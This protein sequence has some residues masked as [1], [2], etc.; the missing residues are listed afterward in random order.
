MGFE[1]YR[2]GDLLL[3]AGTQEVTRNGESVPVPRLSFR[4]LLSLARHAPNVVSTQKLEEEVWSGLVVDKGTINKRVLLLRKALGEDR[5]QGPYITVIRGSGYRMDI[6]V[7]RIA[8]GPDQPESATKDQTSLYQR[9]SGVVRTASYWLLGVV[10]VL[11]LYQGVRNTSQEPADAGPQPKRIAATQAVVVYERQ[12]VAVLPFVDLSGSTNHQFMGDGL[13][14]EIINLLAGMDGLKVAARTSSFAFRETSLTAMEIAQE[15]KVGTILEGSIRLE[16]EDIH[17][18]AQL[19]DTRTGY[20]IWS[21]TYDRTLEQVFGVQDDIAINIAEALKLTLDESQRPDSGKDTTHDIEAFSMYLKGR[22]LMNDRIQLRTEG[23]KKALGLFRQ[24]VQRDQKFARAHAGIAAVYWLLTAYD[25]SLDREPYFEQA[26]ASAQY[27]LEIDPNSTD[28]MGVLA[29]IYAAR[30]DIEKAVMMFN[31]IRE[32]GSNDSNIV[33]W[34]AML[35][36]RL[37]YFSG[38]INEL[39]ETYRRDPL[40]QHIGWSLAAAL[41]FSGRP[42]EAAKILVELDDFAY[43]DH[44]LG[45]TSIYTG[46]YQQARGYLRDARL[47]SGVLPA[48]YADK[49]IDALE[50]PNGPDECARMIMNAATRG[51]L[52]E[53]VNFEALL[54]LGSPRAFELEIDP[55]SIAKTQILTQVW[56]N[57]GVAL[58]QDPRFKAWLQQLGYAEFWRKYG[59]PD[60]C[61]PTSL[62]DFECN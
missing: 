3:D 12:S 8:S 55:L 38:I 19:I 9:S 56:N 25:L 37:G 4:L 61:R 44:S 48:Y 21:K 47:R 20:H 43:R 16:A 42:D 23:L 33:H 15:L 49:L 41:N 1:R 13:A 30:G 28:A 11:A 2:I 57:W 35:Q 32:I 24:A 26:E 46:D 40:N 62:D 5:G 58:R 7:T 52:D 34:E 18:S 53:L 17:V 50:D 29:S 60:R 22:Q 31:Q 39:E 45:L 54:I 10:A 36:M 6:P 51:D 27:A 59:W 14:E